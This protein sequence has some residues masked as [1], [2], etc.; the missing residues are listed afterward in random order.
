MTA[1]GRIVRVSSA[2]EAR[3]IGLSSVPAGRGVADGGLEGRAVDVAGG[4]LETGRWIGSEPAGRVSVADPHPAMRIETAAMTAAMTIPFERVVLIIGRPPAWIS[5][6]DFDERASGLAG[7][8][9]KP[10]SR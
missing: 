3:S 2:R 8:P 7:D 6:S 9:R 10:F 1:L 4:R 5:L